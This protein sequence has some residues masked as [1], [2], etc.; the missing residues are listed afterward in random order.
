MSLLLTDNKYACNEAFIYAYIVLLTAKNHGIHCVSR[1]SIR[2]LRYE[3]NALSPIPV[4]LLSSV[5]VYGLH[6]MS[7]TTQNI[8]IERPKHAFIYFV[9]EHV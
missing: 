5:C 9:L 4:E 8:Y 3:F 6:Y 1:Y 2:I 7:K